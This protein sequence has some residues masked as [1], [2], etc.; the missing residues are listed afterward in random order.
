MPFEV[1]FYKLYPS[2]LKSIT[3]LCYIIN[4]MVYDDLDAKPGH[5]HDNVLINMLCGIV[6]F[7]ESTYKGVHLTGGF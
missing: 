6:N 3:C 7:S 2:S 5:Q 4:I 1:N